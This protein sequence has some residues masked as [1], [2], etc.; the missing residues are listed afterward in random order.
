VELKSWLHLPQQEGDWGLF[1]PPSFRNMQIFVKTLTGKTIILEVE[2][3]DT[4]MQIAEKIQDKEGI[5]PDQIRLIFAG[6]EIYRVGPVNVNHNVEV[7]QSIHSIRPIPKFL[8]RS[9]PV[10]V[11]GSSRSE[12]GVCQV[13]LYVQC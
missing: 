2:S 1:L 9:H 13:N 7:G 3:S 6:K 11:D 8:I 12:G 10:V 5:P 4:M